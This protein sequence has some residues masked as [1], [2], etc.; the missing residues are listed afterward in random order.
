MGLLAVRSCLNTKANI[1]AQFSQPG[2]FGPGLSE[3][4]ISGAIERIGLLDGNSLSISAFTREGW[5]D[6][7]KMAQVTFPLQL[8]CLSL[9]ILVDHSDGDQ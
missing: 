7:Q 3:K 4:F 5:S 8:L 6:H 1:S 9:Y 2:F